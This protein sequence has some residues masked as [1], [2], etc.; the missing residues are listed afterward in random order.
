MYRYSENEI[1][2]LGLQIGCIIKLNR[3]KKG[4]SQEELGLIIGTNSTMIGRIERNEHSTSWQNLL[5]VSQCLGI[6]FSTLFLLKTASELELM[7]DECEILDKKLTEEKKEY[8][9][10]L[11]K[12]VQQKYS[13]IKGS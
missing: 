9:K 12:T 1:E 11:K 13:F 7:I 8:Y 10:S 6:D 4:I 3:L 5:K 2:Y